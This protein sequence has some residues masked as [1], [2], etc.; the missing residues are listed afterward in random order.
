MDID[1]ILKALDHP[2]KFIGYVSQR[3]NIITKELL[4]A[5]DELDLLGL[6]LEKDGEFPELDD[7]QLLNLMDYSQA[8]GT[9]IDYEYGP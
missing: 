5:Q 7:N 2:V 1:V 8:V 3:R 6:F 4:F 9:A